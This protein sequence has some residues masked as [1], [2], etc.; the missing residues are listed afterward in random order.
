MHTL[1]PQLN[2]PRPGT[3]VAVLYDPKDHGKVELDHRAISTAQTAI[4]TITSARP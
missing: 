4:D 2:Q 3:R 1:L